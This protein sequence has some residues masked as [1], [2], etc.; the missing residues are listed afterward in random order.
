VRE[1]AWIPL[2]VSI[3]VHEQQ[4]AEHGGA[5]GLRDVGLLES[6]LARPRQLRAYSQ[7]ASLFELAAAY[8]GGIIR[9]H[10]FTDGNKRTAFVVAVLFLRRNNLRFHAQPAEAA[11]TF[12]DLAA[13]RIDEKALA[14]WFA[15]NSPKPRRR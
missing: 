10:P 9:N 8:A 2:P 7:D 11:A 6:A 14:T 15:K 13:G 4:L 12:L 1:P 3:A 5:A